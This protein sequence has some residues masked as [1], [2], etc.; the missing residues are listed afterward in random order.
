[1][2]PPPWWH[3]K[4]HPVWQIAQI[5]AVVVCAMALGYANAN[6]FDTGE[7]LTALGSA[8]AAR[9]ILGKRP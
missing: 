2:T 9:V 7:I 1:M 3:A 8:G 5:G 4:D 6:H